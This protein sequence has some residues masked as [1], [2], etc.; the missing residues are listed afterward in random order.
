MDCKFCSEVLRVEDCIKCASCNRTSHFQCVGLLEADFK[1]MLPMNKAK[2]KCPLCKSSNNLSNDAKSLLLMFDE[3]FNNLNS[4][5]ESFKTYVANEFKNITQT[6]KQ[7]SERITDMEASINSVIK[8]IEYFDLEISKID[9]LESKVNELKMTF[10]DIKESQSRSEQWVRRSNIQINGVPQKNGENLIQLIK[11]LAEKANFPLSPDTDID[12]ITRIATKN[13]SSDGRPKPIILKM[14]SRYKKD[15]FLTSL[16]KLK[17]LKACDI[18]FS[19]RQNIIY[20]NDHLSTDNRALFNEAKRLAKQ[21]GYNYC[22]VRNCTI[23]VRQK[24]DS[25]V[26]HITSKDCLKKIS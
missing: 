1:K 23:M 11:A 21:K 20:F 22:W 16:R 14:H 15:D 19:G 7:W 10:Q 9:N 4:T 26:I 13:D 6:V 24:N 18:G 5:I 2:W 3:K 8:K 25:P 17:N 12:F